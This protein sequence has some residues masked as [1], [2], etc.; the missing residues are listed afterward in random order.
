VLTAQ[1]HPVRGYLYIASATL[2]WGVAANLGRAAFTGRLLSGKLQTIDPLILTQS[3]TT[4]SFL[5]L[6]LALLAIR[7]VEGIRVPRADVGRMFLI[8][9]L[10][11][12]ASNY[13]YYVALQRTNV[14]TAITVQYTA[15][16]W[17][18]LYM[19]VCG[20]QRP[21]IR[22]IGAVALAVL[23]ICLVIGIFGAGRLQLDTI[24]V[25][26]SLLAA[27]AFAFYNIG[28]HKVLARYDSWTVMLYIT[29]SAA[30]FWLVVNPPWKIIA[31]HYS[32]LQWAFLL[33]FSLVSI[34]GAY[35]FYFAGLK[36]LEPTRAVV[37]SCLEPV[38]TIL[39][40]AIA[41]DES[42][43]L[44]QMLGIGLVLASILV[45][46]ASE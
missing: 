36:H 10:G 20:L 18:L 16:V 27:F 41:L 34:L 38:F 9:I 37:A 42:V 14:A 30:A 25:G 21:T 19:V 35:S 5:I 11:V 4:F 39:I 8:G 2:L 32:W 40:A 22:R 3:R 45:G 44:V 43:N 31:A 46:K 17:V 1:S 28:G 29:M 24:G 15:P 23:G 33:I 12:S 26:A 13:F 7:G 6:L